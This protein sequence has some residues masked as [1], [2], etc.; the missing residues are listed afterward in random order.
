M[1]KE[2]RIKELMQ[3]LI[4]LLL[5]FAWS[6]EVIAQHEHM[7]DDHP[8]PEGSTVGHVD[9]MVSC[10]E[11][12]QDDF[13]YAL[14]MMH[15]MMYVSSRNAFEKIIENNPDC[16]MAYWGVATTLFQPLW[17]TRPSEEELRRG[18]RKIERAREL[19]Y[20][21]RESYLVESTAG[22]FREPETA[23]FLTR[24]ERWTDGVKDAHLA[25]PDDPD[26]SALYG[27][28]LLTLA[29]RAEPEE[30]NYL[31]DK[32]EE[33]LRNVFEEIPTHPGAIHYSIHATD[34]DG[35]AEN[36]LDMVEVY[37]EIA[38]EVPHALHMPSHIYVRLGDWPEVIEWNKISA[39]AALK[40]PV[41]DAESHHY[42]HAI[43]YLVYAWLQ[44][45]EDD[46]AESYFREAMSKDR[47]Q[48]TFVS[49]FHMAAMPARLA[50]EQRDWERAATLE[51]RVPEYLP[52]DQSPWA[53]GLTWFARGLGAVHTG[54]LEKAVDS[55]QRLIELRENAREAD[56]HAMVSYIE[57][58][59]LVL[60]GWIAYLEGNKEDALELIN[61]AGEL[62]TSIEK[63]PVT[64]GA[65]M[66]PYE[67][68]G[69]LLMKLD[70]PEEALE[71]YMASD[72]TWPERYNTLLG[73]ARA[74]NEAGRERRA[75]ELF[76]RLVSNAEES[77][78]LKETE[79]SGIFV[80]R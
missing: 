46:K 71:V 74:A 33:V 5:V 66:P 56:D 49:A 4:V 53:E 58:D 20:S 43:D 23:D 42:V 40:H 59:R 31:H 32:A 26:I 77:D 35:R 27:L 34:V 61:S 11:A 30:R 72:N 67:A 80:S 68:L 52:W 25:Y 7:H 62:E 41:N 15:H 73:A 18:W 50:V 38:P 79:E 17:G 48:E 47:H 78:R 69:D 63:H 22:F 51:P 60:S 65:L 57:I 37:G 24:L 13:D 70:R 12:V 39:I 44:K 29:Q 36:A 6:S 8:L 16:A 75:E 45:G 64:P 55:E 54:D 2:K 19:V 76:E 28:S 21:E 10:D 3:G 14:G 9:F 1:E